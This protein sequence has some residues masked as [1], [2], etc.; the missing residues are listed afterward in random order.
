[1][2]FLAFI[3]VLGS[4]GRFGRRTAAVL[5]S[6]GGAVEFAGVQI[7]LDALVFIAVRFR[8]SKE[9]L[10]GWGGGHGARPPSWS[11]T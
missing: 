1:M 8:Q 9:V 7:S 4:R 6:L 3:G 10:E 2:V 11:H 5:A